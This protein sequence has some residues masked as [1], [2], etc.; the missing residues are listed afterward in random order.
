MRR[1]CLQSV[2]HWRVG[3]QERARRS[4]VHSSAEQEPH[5]HVVRVRL[6]RRTAA[7]VGIA[8]LSLTLSSCGLLR[9]DDDAKAP[10]VIPTLVE[11]PPADAGSTTEP[12]SATEQ[13]EPDP[14][15]ATVN[16]TI[17]KT[18][19]L[20]DAR[21]AAHAITATATR[22][23]TAA[24]NVTLPQGTVTQTVTESVTG[25]A[26]VV[27]TTVTAPAEKTTVTCTVTPLTKTSC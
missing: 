24:K 23:V 7:V 25:S 3:P 11:P 8:T 26:R 19:Y 6:P 12:G 4:P 9:G 14:A 17:T 10:V 16:N 21:T 5:P 20:R 2:H 27:T 13:V 1:A 18:S 15:P 22:I